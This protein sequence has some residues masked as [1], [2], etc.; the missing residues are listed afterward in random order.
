M[1]E[2]GRMDRSGAAQL[3]A[4]VQGGPKGRLE[5]S[6]LAHTPPPGRVCAELGAQRAPESWACAP[7][8]S[9]S[10]VCS[11]SLASA[12]QPCPHC[13]ILVPLAARGQLLCEH[14]CPHPGHPPEGVRGPGNSSPQAQLRALEPHPQGALSA[15]KRIQGAQKPRKDLQTDLGG[16]GV[17][18][19]HRDHPRH[20]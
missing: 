18:I 20:L 10:A 9:D 1:A 5:G 2:Q 19:P 8:H 3:L 4:A 13:R 14:L 17:R 7:E 11:L 15:N 6:E 12:T 16:F